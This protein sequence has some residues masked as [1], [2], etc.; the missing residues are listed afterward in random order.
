MIIPL[1]QAELA[2]PNV[3][4]LI[5]G[6][7]QFMLGIGGVCGSW[8][9]YGTYVSF[10]DSRQWRIPF[11]I[12]II[13]AA[14]LSALI[15]LF[16]ESPRWLIKKGRTEDGLRTLAKLHSNG[17]ITDPWVLAEQ[18]QITSQVNYEKEA[19]ARSILD[20]F[21]TK[22]N[23]H[24]V[25]LACAIQAATQMTGVSAIQYYSVTIFVSFFET[26]DFFCLVQLLTP[27]KKQ[28]GI[29]GTQTL[30]YQAINSVI[31]LLGEAL[32]MLFVDKIGRRTIIIWG[33]LAMC[34]TFVVSTILLAR[35]P[36]SADNKGAH[37]GFIIMTWVFNFTFASMGSLCKHFQYHIIY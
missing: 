18:E 21:K 29:T 34:S 31:G 2:H 12:Q 35:F 30:K 13:P 23:F 26:S 11:G 4:G 15:F 22:A 16:P 8:I 6:L 3:R 33:N 14:V 10:H 37:W 25:M 24:R 36:P 1:Y 32:I 28:I 19:E 7:Q 27:F 5:T 20:L 17:D 9:S